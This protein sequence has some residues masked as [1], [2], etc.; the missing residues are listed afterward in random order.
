M[1]SL[2]VLETFEFK[3]MYLPL[4]KGILMTIIFNRLK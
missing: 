4:Q 3:S 2:E 1:D